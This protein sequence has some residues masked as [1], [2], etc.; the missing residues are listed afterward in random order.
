MQVEGH[1]QQ[2]STTEADVRRLGRNTGTQEEGSRKQRVTARHKRK[3]L[4]NRTENQQN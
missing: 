1:W 4:Q 2:D 3:Q